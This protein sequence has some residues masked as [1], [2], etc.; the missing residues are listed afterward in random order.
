MNVLVRRTCFTVTRTSVQAGSVP[1]TRTI[2]TMAD[3]KLIDFLSGWPNPDLLP[4]LQ[5]NSGANA[6]LSHTD[7]AR[8][9][10]KYAPDEGYL[11]LRK[12]VASWLSEFYAPPDVIEYDRICITGGASQ[13]LACI[14]Q[15][16]T[17]S[18]YTRN[19]W[20][21]SPTYFLA[22]RIFDDS[23]FSGKMRAIPEHNGD[24][25]VEFLAEAI[26]KSEADAVAAGN[27]QPKLKTAFPWRKIYKHVIYAVPSFSNPTGYVMSLQNREALVRL[28]R[29]YDAL[30]VTD[31]V[32]DMLQWPT[33]TSE[34][35]QS[36]HCAVEPRMVDID[37][38]LDHGPSEF[39]NA[40]S[41]GSFS[42]IA[43]PGCRTGWAEGTPKFAWALSQTGS[44]RSGGAPS[45]LVAAILNQTLRDGSLEVHIKQKL[46]P[47][48]AKRWKRLT[49]SVQARLGP[50]GVSIVQ[51][52]QQDV[53]GGYFLWLDLPEGIDGDVL[54]KK[55][56]QEEN[57]KLLSGKMFSVQGDSKET[58]FRNN[59]RLCFSYEEYDALDQGICRLERVI[60]SMLTAQ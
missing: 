15:T 20:M 52:K 33:N 14:L 41:N 47:E 5:L 31:D 56:M 40:V 7:I 58:D 55:A 34:G 60:K 13:N 35:S 17:D 57:V 39:G 46:I 59:I 54:R 43:A 44:S 4:S 42:K 24:I 10:L 8:E 12:S 49:Q 36:L 3:A 45:A 38:N 53:A 16:F 21:Q 50:L 25:D 27:D 2:R 23:G 29:E 11:D 19:I 26:K 30:I 9:A 51:A 1:M 22:C 32:Y 28:A 6:V 48:Y 18:V 37:Q